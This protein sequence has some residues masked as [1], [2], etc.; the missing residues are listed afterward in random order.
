MKLTLPAF[1]TRKKGRTL[2][3]AYAA[4]CVLYFLSG[5]LQL[6]Q[7]VPLPEFAP[8]QLI[9]LLGWTIW[10]YLSQFLFLGLAIGLLHNPVKVNR[11]VYSMLLATA[12]SSIV[13]LAFP[14]RLPP[15][16]LQEAGLI[17][18]TFD[19]VDLMFAITNTNCFPS[20]HVALAFLAA[21]GL[22]DERR[23]L[24]PVAL[25]WAASI[26]ISTLT[27]KQH[28]FIDV[29]AGPPL[30]LLCHRV[31]RRVE[32]FHFPSLVGGRG[33]FGESSPRETPNE[34]GLQNEEVRCR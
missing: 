20:L 19:S 16:E 11:V 23:N 1:D 9:P 12:L 27:A 6:R 34:V 29:V 10:V 21:L 30:A 25:L 2:L 26:S 28:Y 7:A 24:F 32:W 22:R 4:F 18:M 33:A 15:R 5:N 8:D 31:V 13:F 14:T 3:K 17:K